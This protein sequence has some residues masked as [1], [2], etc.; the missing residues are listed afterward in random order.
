LPR[1]KITLQYDGTGFRGWQLQNKERTVQGEIE[2]ALQILNKKKLIRV[3]GA[4]RTD[5]GVHAMG[6]VAHFDFNTDLDTCALKDALNGN[7]ARDVRVMDCVVVSP[8]FH[9]RFS[10]LRRYY[11][12]RCRRNIFLLD[13]N[14]SWLTGSVDLTL[15]NEAASVIIG[16]H[17]FTSFSKNSEDLD[18]RRC[19]IY[20]SVWKENGDVV[21]YHV[22]G[23]RFLH[24]M[25]RYL[26]GTMLEI[27]R[28]KIKMEQF[29]ELINHPIENVNIFKAPPQGLVLTRVDY[30]D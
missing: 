6:Q 26:V 11:Q 10:A 12:Y 28:G 9:A 18:H 16:N 22:S 21:N 8:E 17:D 27:S 2:D 3:H 30:D 23:N 5:T 7:L 20:D 24:H 1:F 19:I 13:R 14:Y 15:L 29:K 25:V 4:G